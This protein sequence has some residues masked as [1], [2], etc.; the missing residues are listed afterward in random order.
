MYKTKLKFNMFPSFTNFENNQEKSYVVI[1]KKETTFS[2]NNTFNKFCTVLISFKFLFSNLLSF[3]YIN[4]SKNVLKKSNC[5][6]KNS[7]ES[8]AKNIT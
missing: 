6:R 3:A 4:I 7:L 8:T 1:F 5:N 2:K